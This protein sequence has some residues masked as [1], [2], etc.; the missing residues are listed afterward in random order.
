MRRGREDGVLVRNFWEIFF[1]E[2]IDS[3]C[4]Y[5]FVVFR[6]IIADGEGD[7]THFALKLE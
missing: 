6:P 7:F 5:F 4:F 3:L 2:N 1:G